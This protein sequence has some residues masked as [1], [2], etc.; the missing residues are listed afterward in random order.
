MVARFRK[1]D[2][3][4]SRDPLFETSD[5]ED[6]LFAGKSSI[7]WLGRFPR[8]KI[9]EAFEHHGILPHLRN[10]GF[11]DIRLALSQV[12]PFRQSLRLYD[13]TENPAHLLMELRIHDGTLWP[14]TRLADGPN[15]A[16]PRVLTIDWLTMQNPGGRFT[17]QRPPFPGQEHPGLGMARPLVKMLIALARSMDLEG[18]VNHPNYFHNAWLYREGFRFYDPVNQ[19]RMQ[20]IH[21]DLICLPLAEIAWAI[22]L[23]CV[24]ALATDRWFRWESGLQILPISSR[25]KDRIDSENHRQRTAELFQDKHYALDE[26]R[27]RNLYRERMLRFRGRID[28]SSDDSG[29]KAAYRPGG[30]KMKHA[31]IYDMFREVCDSTPDK[32]AYR[33]KKEGTWYDVTWREQH[34]A[35]SRVSRA[36][37]ALGLNKGD[38]VCV[39]SNTR[40]EWVQAEFGANAP[41]FV[42]VGIYPSNLPE[43]CAFIIEHC[44]AR[45][46]I[47]ENQDQM[48]KLWSVRDRTISVDN[49]IL[50]DGPSDPDRNI[51]CWGDFLA[52]AEE[53][54]PGRLETMVAA[55]SGDDL[56]ALAYTS[57]TTGSPKGVMLSHTN[58]LAGSESAANAL[59]LEPHFENLLFLPLAHIFAKL[60]VFFCARE[61]LTISFAESINTL[62]ENLKEIRPH[63]I[64]SVPRIFEKI[65][66]KIISGVQD[67]G[68]I[69]EKLFNW[70]IGY[71]H[72]GRNLPPGRQTA[73]GM[74]VVQAQT[75]PQAGIRQNPGRPG[76]PSDFCHIRRRSPQ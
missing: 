14:A 66:D 18:I 41:G 72:G 55:V 44:E 1:R 22:E 51:L 50:L 68:G 57:G 62:G 69:K 49:Y 6:Q 35:C 30:G 59:P 7:L 13:R 75:G 74:A 52:R 28:E 5:L 23:G 4:R 12:E 11:P 48:D 63:L 37:I 15:D 53:V 17:A 54:E 19:A 61:A 31:S 65:Y 24:R 70:A 47:V 16:L 73:A 21:R 9:L 25:M 34:E 45:A 46:I 60:I 26:D 40:L 20:A 56:A 2:S 33:Y 67:A 32:I 27:F 64:A 71:R 36:L 76:R 10:L 29:K 38:R 43:D 58:L 3:S 42:I 8:R 39:L